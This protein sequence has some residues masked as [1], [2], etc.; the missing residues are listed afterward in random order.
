[1]T[2]IIKAVAP[3]RIITTVGQ[4]TLLLSAIKQN[5]QIIQTGLKTTETLLGIETTH[6]RSALSVFPVSKLL[7]PF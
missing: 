5:T 6:D 1:M 4:S 2:E 3:L 7:K